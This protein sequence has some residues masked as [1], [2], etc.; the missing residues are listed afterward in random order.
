MLQDIRNKF[1]TIAGH[2]K[3]TI[4]KQGLGVG[5]KFTSQIPKNFQIYD[6]DSYAFLGYDID[7]SYYSD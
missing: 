6:S 2:K 3:M 5:K 4:I 7:S 1:I